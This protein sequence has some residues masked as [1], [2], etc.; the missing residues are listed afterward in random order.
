LRMD[1]PRRRYAA[2]KVSTRVVALQHVCTR[3]VQVVD[4]ATGGKRRRLA[5]QQVLRQ[6]PQHLRTG[7]LVHGT[8]ADLRP[9]AVLLAGVLMVVAVLAAVGRVW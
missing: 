4:R 7:A 1:E 3:S 2:S 5:L 9:A 8:E 6:R